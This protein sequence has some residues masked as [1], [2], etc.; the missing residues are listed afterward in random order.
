[1]WQ[2]EHNGNGT[3]ITYTYGTAASAASYDASTNTISL[4]I[5]TDDSA[6]LNTAKFNTDL[7]GIFTIGGSSGTPTGTSTGTLTASW[8]V[9]PIAAGFQLTAVDGG[10]AD[11]AK[12]N[13]T[14]LVYTA[15][16]GASTRLRTMQLRT[17]STSVLQLERQS[18]TSLQQS[19]QRMRSFTSNISKAVPSTHRSTVRQ[20]LVQLV[21]TSL[22]LR[23]LSL[24]QSM[25]G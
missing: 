21:P 16:T 14:T 10:A 3:K 20:A 18:L 6:A 17:S 5:D 25:A 15:A 23:P 24:R 1:M 22:L 2:T 12:G 13:S 4:T 7:S 8:P 9:V 19:I 11:G